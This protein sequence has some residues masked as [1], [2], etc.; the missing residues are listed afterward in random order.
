[1]ARIWVVWISVFMALLILMQWAN[2]SELKFGFQSLVTGWFLFSVLVVL[3]LFNIRKKLSNL[4]LANSSSWLSLHLPMG[5]LAVG[6]FWLHTGSHWPLGIYEK[7]LAFLFYTTIL[8]GILGLVIQRSFPRRL[9]QSGAEY[10]FERIPMEIIEIQ[11]KAKELLLTCTRETRRDTLAAQFL[12]HLDWYFQRP[13]FFLNHVLGG[14][15]SDTWIRQ[16]CS[17]MELV[18]NLQERTYLQKLFALANTKKSI[19]LHFA[20]Q[21]VLKCWIMFHLPLAAAL[22]TLALWH[23]LVVYVYFL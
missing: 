18:L 1:M 9:T 11:K 22:M 3:V 5:F 23:L 19:D 21:S 14:N 15:K 7:Y 12:E 2:Q 6:I 13:R 16:Q 17:N 10:I 4:P 20:L 8:T